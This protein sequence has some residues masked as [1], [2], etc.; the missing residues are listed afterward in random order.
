MKR[1]RKTGGSPSWEER[2]R[3]WKRPLALG[4]RKEKK[5]RG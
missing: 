2:K 4:A 1:D 3:N 5:T